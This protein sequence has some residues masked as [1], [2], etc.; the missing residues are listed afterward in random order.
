[1]IQGSDEW[2]DWRK[3]HIT[4]SDAYTICEGSESAQIKLYEEKKGLSEPKFQTAAMKHGKDLENEAR[5]FFCNT[6]ANETFWP[7]TIVSDE[8]KFMAT[9]LDGLGFNTGEIL[10]IKCPYTSNLIERCRECDIPIQYIIQMNHHMIVAKQDFCHFFVYKN[11]NEYHYEKIQRDIDLCNKIIEKEKE[12]FE[13][14]Q[15]DDIPLKK[16]KTDEM[17]RLESDLLKSKKLIKVYQEEYDRCLQKIKDLSEWESFEGKHLRIV[18]SY[19]KGSVDYS[20]IPELDCVD[21]EKYRKKPTLCWLVKDIRQ[22]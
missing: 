4:S 14:L 10:E 22:S 20:K 3:Q 18:K 19:R 8:Y 17:E 9:S 13:K 11:E 5:E 2:F 1:M 6:F 16:I 12:F 21:I 15:N 7:S